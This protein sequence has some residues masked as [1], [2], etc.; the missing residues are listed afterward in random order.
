MEKTQAN[1]IE[2]QVRSAFTEGLVERVQVLTYGD[3][4]AVEPGETAIRVFISRA[5]RPEGKDADKEIIEAFQQASFEALKR[6]SDELPVIGW[7]DFR[8]ATQ[9]ESARAGGPFGTGPSFRFKN[10]REPCPPPDELSEQLT[11]VMTRLGVADLTTVDT[12]IAAGIAN[13]RAEVLRWAVG[14]LREHPA[15]AQL[16]D[17]VHEISE[18][19]AQ[20]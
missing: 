1:R 10:R 15:Y 5:G 2:E 14:R 6:L 12:L 9:E 17:R 16:Q 3:D 7:I 4:P 11:P 13:S 8:P 20:F 18:L 19:K